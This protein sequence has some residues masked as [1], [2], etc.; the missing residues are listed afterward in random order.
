MILHPAVVALL[1]GSALGAGLLLHAAWDAVELLR[2]WD[3]ASGSSRQLALERRTYLLSVI[4]A[5]VFAYEL[6]SLLLFVRTADVLAP[7]FT[8]AMCAAGTLAANPWGYPALLVRLAV[9]V[10]AG[11]WLVVNHADALGHDHP[12]LRAKYGLLLGLTPLALLGA[13]LQARF[14]L[15]LDP[16]VITSCCGSLFSRGGAGPGALL[17]AVPAAPAAVAL[18]ATAAGAVAAGGALERRPGPAAGL[19][20]AGAS[21][22]AA[23]A[24]LVGLVAF[25]SPYVYE[26]PAHRCP[27]CLLQAEYHWVGYPLHAALVGGAIAGN[28]AGLLAAFA[29]HASLARSLPRLTARLALASSILFTAFA[30]VAAGLVLSSKLRS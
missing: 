22:L 9:A 27:F 11:L 20:L 26:L 5:F 6:L 1:A 18:F 3:P 15:A 24:G 19:A 29:R 8:G 14:F 25:V 12:L 16:E 23:V 21:T 10:L 17:A 30:V 4:V 2:R 13:W 7:L 28:G